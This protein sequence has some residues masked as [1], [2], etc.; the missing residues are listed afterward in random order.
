MSQP[1]DI[2]LTRALPKVELHAHLTGSISRECLHQIWLQK[3]TKAP[4]FE[5]DDPLTA[6]PKAADGSIDVFR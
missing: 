4:A 2:T 6:I 5:M 3:K 1:P